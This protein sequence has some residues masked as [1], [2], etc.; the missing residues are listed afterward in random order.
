ML[1]AARPIS[2]P[3]ASISPTIWP[4]AGPPM[5]GLQ[6]IQPILLSSMVHR[7]VSHPSR[8]AARDASIP[9]WPP[10]ITMTSTFFVLISR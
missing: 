7:S 3:R 4:F 2:P 10:P 8:A 9:A 1:S 5:E 6:G